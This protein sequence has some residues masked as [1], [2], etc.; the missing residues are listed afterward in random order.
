MVLPAFGF[1]PTP[2]AHP[3]PLS[4]SHPLYTSSLILQELKKSVTKTSS[5]SCVTE[6]VIIYNYSTYAVNLASLQLGINEPEWLEYLKLVAISRNIKYST[7]PVFS[8]PVTYCLTD[9][10]IPIVYFYWQVFSFLEYFPQT[11]IAICLICAVYALL[12]IG[13]AI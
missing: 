9:L 8:D 7:K 1:P 5:A 11:N 4:P 6:L 10:P 13:C 3:T 12:I 2:N